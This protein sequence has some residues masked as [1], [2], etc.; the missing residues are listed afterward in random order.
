MRYTLLYLLLNA[1]KNCRS[2][3]L[4]ILCT[5]HNDFFFFFAVLRTYEVK[6]SF[7]TQSTQ[8]PFVTLLSRRAQSG[9]WPSFG[10]RVWFTESH[11]VL[12]IYFLLVLFTQFTLDVK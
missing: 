10:K 12:I 7:S 6:A 3:V 1:K 2:Y 4:H 11:I 8:S 9:R 5:T